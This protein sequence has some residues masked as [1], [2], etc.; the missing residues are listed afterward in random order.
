MLEELLSATKR[1]SDENEIYKVIISAL[2]KFEAELIDKNIEQLSKGEQSTGDKT[3]PYASEDYKK[4]KKNIG[5][6]SGDYA[7][8]ILEGDFTEGIFVEFE[9]Y[10][11]LFDSKDSKTPKLE[12]RD[13]FILGLQSKSFIDVL[14]MAEDEIIKIFRNEFTK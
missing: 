9:D 7:D 5:S 13:P 14:I 6:K 11:I 3:T 1:F 8:Y 12:D 2:E 10:Y 4:Y